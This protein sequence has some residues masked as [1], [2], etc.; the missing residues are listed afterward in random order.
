MKN[1]YLLFL[2]LFGVKTAFGQETKKEQIFK[3]HP[4]SLTTGALGFSNE[5][6]NQEKTRSLVISYAFRYKNNSSDQVDYN[7]SGSSY[8]QFNNWKGLALGIDRRFYVPAFQTGDKLGF[9]PDKSK[10]G[11]YL[12][13]GIKAEYNHNDFDKSY[14]SQIYNNTQGTP[15]SVFIK[16]KETNSYLS[17]MPNVNLGIQFTLFQNLYL[18]AFAGGGIRFISKKQLASD[19]SNNS[20]GGSYYN[21]GNGLIESFTLKEGVVPNFGFSL[22][23]N[24]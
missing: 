3:F 5:F 23:L 20:I 7:A 21:L 11:V 19:K 24:F 4:F 10:L 18:D 13:A 12:S 15:N 22:G 2:L 1:K 16:N 14:F 6:L 9:M 8:E 17:A